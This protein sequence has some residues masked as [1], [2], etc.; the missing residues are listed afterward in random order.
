MEAGTVLVNE[1]II[2][3]VSS[4]IAVPAGYE[5]I[6]VDGRYLLPGMINL[7]AHLFGTGKPSKNLGG[8]KN[9]ERILKFI[10]SPLGK[11]VIDSMLYEQ[12]RLDHSQLFLD[13]LKETIVKENIDALLVAG[14]VFDTVL[15]SNAAE[16]QYYSFLS[17]L[18]GTC[19]KHTIITAGNHGGLACPRH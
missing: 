10:N 15:P 16:K 7:H 11:P 12:K 19:C 2:E 6:D 18:C 3:K 14:D 17:S 5:V 8:G 9:Q 13:W 4:K 1:G